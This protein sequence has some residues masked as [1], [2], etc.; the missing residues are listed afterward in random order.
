MPEP[1]PLDIE[2]ARMVRNRIR[3]ELD[4][5]DS[6]ILMAELGAVT[7]EQWWK[8]W[9]ALVYEMTLIL[10]DAATFRSEAKHADINEQLRIAR[11]LSAEYVAQHRE[12]T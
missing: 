7:H 10:R 11:E 8:H 6:G 5:F 2:S 1:A 3:A 9:Q 4:Q 12:S